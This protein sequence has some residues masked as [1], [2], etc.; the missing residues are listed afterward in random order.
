M[1]KLYIFLP[2]IDSGTK[3]LTAKAI[4]TLPF[5][6]GKHL[7]GAVSCV[8]LEKGCLHNNGRLQADKGKEPDE[9][10]NR[11]R[12]QRRVISEEDV[13]L[14]CKLEMGKLG[15]TLRK[16]GQELLACSAAG[17]EGSFHGKAWGSWKK[18]GKKVL[19]Q[20]SKETTERKLSKIQLLL[21]PQSS[22]KHRKE[23]VW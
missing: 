3:L 20:A 12:S 23:F 1:F 7:G 15:Q 9:T 10:E 2:N 4:A 16:T 13:G 5:P 18:A 22:P 21:W 11:E 6:C 14:T 8:G 17:S 19:R